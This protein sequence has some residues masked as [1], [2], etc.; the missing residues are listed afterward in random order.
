MLGLPALLIISAMRATP[1]P[2]RVEVARWAVVVSLIAANNVVITM[3][4][5]M[6]ILMYS[7]YDAIPWAEGVGGVL[8][9]G[10]SIV[11][12]L[13]VDRAPAPDADTADGQTPASVTGAP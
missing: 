7:G 13:T 5:A 10:A 3:S 12:W 1:G 6:A 8:L 2:P 4:L 11:L 9:I